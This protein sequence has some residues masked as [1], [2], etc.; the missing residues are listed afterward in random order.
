MDPVELLRSYSN[1]ISSVLPALRRL[2]RRLATL[3]S[4]PVVVSPAKSRF[5]HKVEQRLPPEAIQQLVVDHKAGQ[6]TRSLMRTT[7]SARALSFV[8]W[9]RPVLESATRV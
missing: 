5:T 1:P 3:R 9:L 6:S 2:D 7:G 8:S 4:E